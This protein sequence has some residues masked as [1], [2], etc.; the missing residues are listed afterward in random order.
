M[1]SWNIPALINKISEDV[2]A[3]KA[4]L[5]ALFKWTDADTTDVPVGAKRL[6]DVAGGRQM[7]EYS[8]S[9]WGNVGKLMHDV[10]MLDGKHAST[11]Q[12]ADTIPVRDA[13]GTIPGNISGNAA[14]ATEASS[15]AS[16][17]TTPVANG[18]TGATTEAGARASLG[19]DNASNISSGI[20]DIAYGGTGSSTKNFVDLTSN[21]NV[22]G[23]KTFSAM[24]QI[25]FADVANDTTQN[26]L[27]GKIATNDYFRIAAGGAS[28]AGWVEIATA[29]DGN[30]PI[31]ARQY[32]GTFGSVVHE[33]KLLDDSGN[34]SFPGSVTASGGFVGN[35]SSATKATQDGDGNVIKNTYLKL[36][37]GTMTGQLTIKPAGPGIKLCN[38]IVQ[39][40]T[41]PSSNTWTYIEFFD[42]AN[43]RLGWVGNSYDKNG[44]NAMQ[45]VIRK[46]DANTEAS[47][48]VGYNASKVAY[49]WAPTPANASNST[50]IATT[51]FVKAQGYITSSGSISGN[52]ATATK[53]TKDSANQQINTT[54][55]KALS[56]SGKVITY[57]K[58]DG[59]TGTI[60]TQD[61]NTTYANMKGATASA[62]GAAGLVPAPAKG[63]QGQYLRGD[64][65]WATPTN[66]TYANFVKS[67]SS[68]AAGLVPKP[69]TTAGTTKY[70][71]EDCSW[72]VPPNTNTTYG[73]FNKTTNGLVPAPGN[74]HYRWD[75]YL[76]GDGTWVSAATAGSDR[77]LKQNFKDVPE[78]IIDIWGDVHWIQFLYK[79][80]VAEEGE[81]ARPHVG[82][83]V[84][85][86]HE[87]YEKHGIDIKKYGITTHDL[88]EAIPAKYDEDGNLIS[89]QQEAVDR[90]M[91]NYNN[92]FAFE[93][94]Y[95]RKKIRLIEE[96]LARVESKVD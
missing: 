78:D 44:V 71:R 61:T 39:K 40:G 41:N 68:A 20:L 17:Y 16:G 83:V 23:T 3:I 63:K 93:A 9:A 64:G 46:Q 89:S 22:G 91:L 77:R 81:H 92:A 5:T 88:R 87:V 1:A 19:A 54:Y 47:I 48:G 94:L 14:T 69:S 7:Q 72:Q 32:S 76:A 26:I 62:A 53:A 25:T 59:T 80:D 55:I 6:Q 10:D 4:L 37:G 30:E 96:R 36:G 49:T 8:G 24:K 74:N 12:T 79:R 65:A 58:G 29:D 2:P 60:T 52:A 84:Q 21:Q 50:E 18:G 13:N 11:A 45:L 28:N 85:D 75:W 51:A 43:V 90:W 73:V 70:L 33:A 34:T 56:V 82:L 27:Y 42:K 35:A 95:L 86:L 31:Y 66:T 38:D 57:T 67:G 15:L